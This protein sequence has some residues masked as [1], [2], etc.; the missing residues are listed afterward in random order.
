MPDLIIKNALILDGT[1]KAPYPADL[2]VKADRIQEIGTIKPGPKDQVIDA[3]GLALSPGFVDV[4]GHS[5]YHLLVVP[6][7]ESKILQGMTTEIGGN[8][9]Y[10]A[11][12]IQGGIKKERAKF[13]KDELGVRLNFQELKEYFAELKR[14]KIG[15]N[16]GELVGYNTVRGNVIGYRRNAPD[17]KEM[18][19]IQAQI[20]KALME[21][22]F[23]MSAGLI[24]AP[25][26][27]TTAEELIEALAPVNEADGIFSCHLR[28]EGDRLLEAIEE[29]I[30]IGKKA[31]VKL[32]LSH[33]KTGGPKNW[34]K[35]DRAFELIESAQKHGVRIK[36]DRYPYTAS[37]TSLSAV[38]PDW[39]FEGGEEEYRRRLKADKQRIK[40][41]LEQQYDADYWTRIALSQVFSGRA[42]EMEG[43]TVAA[44][45]Q[46]K[47]VRPAEFMVELLEKEP[48][49]PNA[50]FYSMSEENLDRI[51]LKD[52]VMLGSDSGAR[53]FSGVLAKGKPHPR[54]FGAFP[55]FFAQFVREKKLF[56]LAEAVR[57]CAWMGCEHFGIR[58]RGKIE[59]G[60]FADLVLFDPEKISDCADYENPFQAPLGIE[61]VLVNGEIAVKRG[62]LTGKMAGKI[63]R[64]EQ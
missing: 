62:K 44:L 43:K 16:F 1:G 25:G 49:S 10:S 29:F 23:G 55:R 59:K 33:L 34:S 20:E 15:V 8:C 2:K 22:A 11:A 30:D 13:L 28:S 37:F 39:V 21:G 36:A 17:A 24:Y 40:N 48:V 3:K 41:E 7:A 60:F 31:R 12:P 51:F 4:H 32:E 57:K 18:K 14:K 58:E 27:F 52:W 5:D 46:K 9:G 56:G 26:T 38:L 54:V 6:G 45:A 64:K 61:M 53:G 50:I 63:I 42:G 47:S 35:L 19:K